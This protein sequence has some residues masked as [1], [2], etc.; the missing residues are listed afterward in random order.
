[1]SIKKEDIQK[2]LGRKSNSRGVFAVDKGVSGIRLSRCSRTSDDH[3]EPGDEVTV[4]MGECGKCE[5]EVR[6]VIIGDQWTCYQVLVEPS[7]KTDR[8]F[9]FVDDEWVE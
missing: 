5:A 7:D 6:S 1:M 3:C 2:E 4:D 9:F 8:L